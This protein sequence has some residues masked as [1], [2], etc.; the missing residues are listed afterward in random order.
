M[1]RAI[2][3]FSAGCPLCTDTIELVNTL[4][5]GGAGSTRSRHAARRDRDPRAGAG[6]PQPARRRGGRHAGGML[7]G[8]RTGRAG[9]AR[10]AALSR[11]AAAARVTSARPVAPHRTMRGTVKLRRRTGPCG[12]TTSHE[13]DFVTS[14]CECV[15]G[16]P[17]NRLSSSRA[18]LRS[19]DGVRFALTLTTVWL[20]TSHAFAPGRPDGP[21]AWHLLRKP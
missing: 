4:V 1:P 6:R 12:A 14:W 16:P 15:G 7:R 3:I 13:Y 8:A 19:T 20:L 18:L 5:S 2:E 10:R 9:P 17:Q 21:E 11:G